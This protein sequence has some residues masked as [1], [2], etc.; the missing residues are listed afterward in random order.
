MSALA[1]T[2]ICIGALLIVLFILYFHYNNREIALRKESDAQRGKIEAVR[3]QM[4]KVLQEKASVASD[5]RD[6]FAKIFPEIIAGRYSHGGGEMM[7]WIQ[8]ANPNFDTSLYHNLMVAIKAQ[9]AQ[10]MN[11]QAR[12]LDI[13]NQRA[14]LVESYPSRWFVKNKAAIDYEVIAGNDT[15]MTMA[16]GIDDFT[17]NLK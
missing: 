7:K 5:Y 16:T 14:T 4:F 8:E 9:R 1:I 3:D 15:K 10:F 6:A 12:M 11:T 2:F 13:I 17:I